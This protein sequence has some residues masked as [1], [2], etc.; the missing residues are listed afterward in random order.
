MTTLIVFENKIK[1]AS[2][3]AR[4]SQH[5]QFPAEDLQVDAIAQSWRSRYGSGSGCGLFVVDD[6]NKYIDFDEGG[7]ELTATLT[8]GNYNGQTLAA[9]IKTQMDVAG[10]LTYTVTYNES[11][12]KFTIAATS[13]FTLRWNTGTHKTQ[14]ISDLCGYDD[15]ANDTGASSYTADYQRIH[16]EE[17]IDFDLGAAYAIDYLA[18]IGHNLT[19]SAALI[20]YVGATN[21]GFT[22]GVVNED[23]TYNASNIRKVLSSAQS[24][25]YW[26]I[27]LKDKANSAGF[28]NIGVPIVGI[29]WQPNR[30]FVKPYSRGAQD[31]SDTGR[32]DSQVLYS[33]KKAILEDGVF[34]FRGLND[35]NA[36]KA[37]EFIKTAGITEGFDVNFDPSSPNSDALWAANRSLN[38]PQYQHYDYWNWD[39][40]ILEM[41]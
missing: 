28:L 24:K 40:D 8:T 20:R 4:S 7:S 32:S 30:D 25:R 26:R 19:A 41:K 21:S 13:N 16:S 10:A 39:L 11:T 35:T 15:S 14:D 6:N 12:L 2:I 38:S 5:P 18:L 3:L 36:D 22:T 31:P 1:T 17:K 23:L 34:P 9:E 27:H 37:R 29:K 33:S